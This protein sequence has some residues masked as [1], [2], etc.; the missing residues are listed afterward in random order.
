[1]KTI[2]H[3]YE[4]ELEMGTDSNCRPTSQ[5]YILRKVDGRLHAASLEALVA[6]GELRCQSSGNRDDYLHQVAQDTIDEIEEWA[7]ENGY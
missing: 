4:V 6:E 7:I 3:G 5:C 1:M 2:I